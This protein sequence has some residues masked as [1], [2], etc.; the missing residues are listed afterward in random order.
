MEEIN[1]L[2]QKL[3]EENLSHIIKNI[4]EIKETKNKD[5]IRKLII[6]IDMEKFP[7]HI[8]SDIEK[9]VKIAAIKLYL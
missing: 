9:K 8:T 4:K 7:S 2:F 6:L 1:L 3:N 5:D